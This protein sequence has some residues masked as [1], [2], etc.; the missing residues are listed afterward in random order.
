M[1]KYFF[2]FSTLLGYLMGI[3]MYLSYFF[4]GTSWNNKGLLLV[5]VIVG[6]FLPFYSKFSNKIE[7]FIN[8]KTSFITLGRTARFIFQL[9][10]NIF[11][12]KIFILFNVI[13]NFNIKEL[14]GVI[15]ISFMTTVSSQG[16]QYFCLALSNREIGNKNINVMIGLSIN[17]VITSLAVLGIKFLKDFFVVNSIFFGI[18]GLGIGILSDLR[19]IFPIKG[20]IGIF[21]GTFNPFHKMHLE[22]IKEFMIERQLERIYIHSTVIPKIHL[23][24]L[25]KGEIIVAKRENGMKVY[26]ITKKSD[27]NVNYFPTGNKFFEFETRRKIIELVIEEEKLD[28]KVIVMNEVLLYEK[29]GFYEIIKKIKK[30]NP[31]KRLHGLHGSD[32]GGMWVRNIYDESGWIYP[33]SIIRKNLISSTLIREGVKGMAS[34]IIEEIL[35]NIAKGKEA[36]VVKNKTFDFY[37]DILREIIKG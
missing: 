8:L 11:I 20:G 32:I 15:G 22:I 35:D 1:K 31:N 7:E 12:F 24:A 17:I 5:V 25:R 3:I 6:F 34:E 28:D 30:L 27:I 26:E 2:S 10:F 36:F 33:Y 9:F 16:I 23:D 21:F 13:S 14:G 18:I 19:R 29:N 37:D 4:I